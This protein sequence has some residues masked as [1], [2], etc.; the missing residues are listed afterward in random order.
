[1]DDM[2]RTVLIAYVAPGGATQLVPLAPADAG[3]PISMRINNE[4]RSVHQACHHADRMRLQ[5]HAARED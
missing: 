4:G 1:M 3:P 2:V 5:V